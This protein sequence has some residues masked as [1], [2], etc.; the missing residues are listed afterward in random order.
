MER[1]DLF[2]M[3]AQLRQP[4][5]TVGEL[6]LLMTN[7]IR[8]EFEHNVSQQIYISNEL[9]ARVRSTK[10][11]MIMIINKVGMSI[12]PQAPAK[13]LSRVMMEYL[14][15]MDGLMPTS[16]TLEFIKAE[17]KTIY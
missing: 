16:K 9:W 15:E 1:I 8:M 12:P 17:A 11:E 3:L 4:G 2:Y 6:Q 7:Q 5:M 13:E 14:N 10:E